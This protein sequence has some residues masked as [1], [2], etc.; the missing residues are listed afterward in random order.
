MTGSV[1]NG[2]VGQSL[3]GGDNNRLFRRGNALPIARPAQGAR[4][5]LQVSEG[6]VHIRLQRHKIFQDSVNTLL[7]SVEDQRCAQQFT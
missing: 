1:H 2:H 3:T 7:K 4:W 5:V 6:L